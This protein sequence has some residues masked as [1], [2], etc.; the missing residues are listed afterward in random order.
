MTEDTPQSRVTDSSTTSVHEIRSVS[1][2]MDLSESPSFLLRAFDFCVSCLANYLGEN[3]F[4]SLKSIIC[5]S[6]IPLKL[7]RLALCGYSA[8]P[9]QLAGLFLRTVCYYSATF[10]FFL[11][12]SFL[13]AWM[14]NRFPLLFLVF[15]KERKS[16]GEPSIDLYS[17][18]FGSVYRTW[19]IIMCSSTQ[20]IRLLEVL[21]F[22]RRKVFRRV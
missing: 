5:E 1:D 7:S 8:N 12:S 14:S 3:G 22:V 4:T 2:I 13:R 9:R 21:T 17:G 20:T 11:P 15:S 16:A 18:L 6:L 10:T 19:F